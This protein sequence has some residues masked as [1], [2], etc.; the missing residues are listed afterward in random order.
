MS[1]ASQRKI[2]EAIKQE[3][4]KGRTTFLRYLCV[5]GY[6]YFMPP[7][8]Y[9]Y[10]C[11]QYAIS[12]EHIYI[13]MHICTFQSYVLLTNYI[14]YIIHHLY[15]YTENMDLAYEHLPEAFARVNMLYVSICI[16]DYPIKAFVDSGAQSTIMS[17]SCAEKCN[18]MRLL[19]TRFAGEAR[20]VGTG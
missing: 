2:E 5:C 20:G 10:A 6:I 3:N 19:D 15:I 7:L 18:V 1:E 14:L 11:T 16:N 4:I 17:K 12:S 13:Y 9:M 8:L